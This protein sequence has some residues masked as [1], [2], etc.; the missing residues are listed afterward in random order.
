MHTIHP[1]HGTNSIERLSHPLYYASVVLI[2]YKNNSEASFWE[3]SMASLQQSK[4]TADLKSNRLNITLPTTAS[5]KEVEKI[6]TDIRFCIADLKPGFCVVTD[7]SQCTFAHLSAISP[8]RQIMDYLVSKQPGNI[9]RVMGK[10]GLIT[11]QLLRFTDKFQS[12]TPV[13]VN[14]YEEAEEYLANNT[15]RKGLRFKLHG[16]PVECTINQKTGSG[17]LIDISVSG[18]AVQGMTLPLSPEQE[19]S[20][21]IPMNHGNDH[22]SAFTS[23]ANV[24]RV[25][26]DMFAAQFHDLDEDQIAVLFKWLA[27][28]VGKNKP[29]KE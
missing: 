14:T 9:I 5:Q 27:Y 6:Y 8:M 29:V 2:F 19:I 26:E 16:H 12:Y 21:I 3:E 22:T 18:F 13:Y 20:I 4:V 17:A 10:T 11:K 25:Q 15:K 28:E 23:M 7:Y 1:A 24:V